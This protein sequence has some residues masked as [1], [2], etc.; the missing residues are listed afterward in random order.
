MRRSRSP[1][2]SASSASRRS[3]SSIRC[4]RRSASAACSFATAVSVETSRSPARR[5]AARTCSASWSACL[6]ARSRMPSASIRAFSRMRRASPRAEVASAFAAAASVRA[7]AAATR[8]SSSALGPGPDA[9]R[10]RRARS[11]HVPTGSSARSCFAPTGGLGGGR[12]PAEG[13]ARRP[14]RAGVG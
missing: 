2:R 9:H 8:A 1:R 13:D 5:A 12:G 10:A 6:W 4:C 11:S 14:G 3:R 7:A